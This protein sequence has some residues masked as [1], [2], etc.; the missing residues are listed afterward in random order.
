M[1]LLGEYILIP[2][3]NSGQKEWLKLELFLDNE[4]QCIYPKLY[5]R[6]EFSIKYGRNKKESKKWLWFEECGWFLPW[7]SY[8]L[9]TSE[10]EA[11]HV[12]KIWINCRMKG[13][14]IPEEIKTMIQHNL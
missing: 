14:D 1:K 10:E 4:K 12:M 2:T 8:I 3:L 5:A 9:S 13:E 6:D 7:D 11:L